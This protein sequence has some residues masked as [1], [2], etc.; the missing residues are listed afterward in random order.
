MRKFS[1]Y[2][3]LNTK[4]HYYAPRTALIENAY[5]QLIGETPEEGGHY[6]TVW[7]PRQTGKSSV[8]LEV[9]KTLRQQD[10]FDVVLM[11]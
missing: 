1:S 3:Q 7:A 6:I 11:T 4:Q 2:G 9:T 10:A 5:T 8:M